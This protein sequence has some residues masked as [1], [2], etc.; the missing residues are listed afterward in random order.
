MD[1][2]PRGGGRSSRTT[3]EMDPS[4]P[5]CYSEVEWG[6]DVTSDVTEEFLS[7]GVVQSRRVRD[8]TA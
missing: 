8:R 6:L 4:T 5:V 2:E 7:S 1:G 3:L